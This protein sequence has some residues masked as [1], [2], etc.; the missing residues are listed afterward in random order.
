MNSPAVVRH[1]SFAKRLLKQRMV[2]A[3][4]L[5]RLSQSI[6]NT[7]T[8]RHDCLARASV[9]SSKCTVNI[10]KIAASFSPLYD[11]QLDYNTVWRNGEGISLLQ[12]RYCGHRRERDKLN[13]PARFVH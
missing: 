13:R 8:T 9:S 5:V 7:I 11:E 6:F 2:Y 3:V 4:R 10:L 1:L 12:K